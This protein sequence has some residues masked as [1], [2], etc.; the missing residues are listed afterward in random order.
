MTHVKHLLY[1]ANFVLSATTILQQETTHSH[2]QEGREGK[3]A[4]EV[5]GRESSYI[6]GAQVVWGRYI[7]T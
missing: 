2:S 7:L 1:T 3:A 5:M 6:L 4:N